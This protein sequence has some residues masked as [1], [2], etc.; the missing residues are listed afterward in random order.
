MADTFRSHFP[1]LAASAGGTILAAFAGS[2]LGPLGT[3]GGLAAGSL[4][5]G[6][7]T[8]W[9]ERGLRR[10]AEIARATTRFTER[11]RRPPTGAEETVIIRAI[12]ASPRFRRVRWDH[13]GRLAAGAAALG[14]IAVTAV[15]LGAGK[16]ASAIVQGKPGHGLTVTGGAPAAPTRSPSS[17]AASA[18]PAPSASP[19]PSPDPL[20]TPSPSA[21]ASPSPSLTVTP[22]ASSPPPTPS[23]VSTTVPA[24]PVPW[25]SQTSPAATA[26]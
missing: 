21:T 13:I 9:A 14:L 20:P 1:A 12:D 3:V 5:A 11:R 2:Y 19:S 6:S 7:A 22:P 10:S 17:P 25:P 18:F 23:P 16:P 26:G 15:E 4:I 8:W 24:T